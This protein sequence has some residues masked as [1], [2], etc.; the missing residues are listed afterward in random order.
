MAM[1]AYTLC[2]AQPP[3]PAYGISITQGEGGDFDVSP[4]GGN[5]APMEVKFGIVESIHPN[6]I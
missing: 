5:V 6:R 1:T 4:F 3:D 2:Y